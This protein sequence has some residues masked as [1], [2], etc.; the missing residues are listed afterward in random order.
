MEFP[1]SIWIGLFA[2]VKSSDNQISF[3]A[4]PVETESWNGFDVT[5]PTW[6]TALYLHFIPIPTHKRKHTA[7]GLRFIF[8]LSIPNLLVFRFA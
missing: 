8:C 3:S 4:G 1:K 6:K 5:Y 7:N 2:L